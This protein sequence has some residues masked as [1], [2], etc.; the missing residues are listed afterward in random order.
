[1][2]NP[3]T[4][5]GIKIDQLLRIPDYKSKGTV[6]ESRHE[7]EIPENIKE[8][9]KV[10]HTIVAGQT[11]YGIAR[12]YG[13]KPSDIEKANPGMIR[14]SLK[15][16]QQIIIPLAQ[17]KKDSASKNFFIHKVQEKETLYSISRLYKTSVDSLK[18]I[19]GL[20][21]DSILRLGMEL[22]V[23]MV[24]G[25]VQQKDMAQTSA[26]T[27]TPVVIS[28]DCDSFLAKTEQN[29]VNLTLLLPFFASKAEGGGEDENVAEEKRHNRQK[30][31]FS[32]QSASYVEFYQGCLLALEDLKR[33]KI[34]VNLQVYD[35]E[36]DTLLLHSIM[37]KPEFQSANVVI[38]PVSLSLMN[39]ASRHMQK[40]G[41]YWVSPFADITNITKGNPFVFQV[42][43]GKENLF[44]ENIKHIPDNDTNK[45]IVVYNGSES[46]INDDFRNAA[47]K[48]KDLKVA[49]MWK[50]LN[51]YHNGFAELVSMLDSTKENIII[52]PSV[53]EIFVSNLLSIL[54]S[55]LLL[56][57]I[58][59]IG[60]TEWTLFSSI[61]MNYLFDQQL[62]YNTPFYIDYESEPVK[63]FLKKY[64]LYFGTEPGQM[65]KQGFNYA[66][67]GYDVTY[68]F[69]MG[70]AQ[71]GN[72]L[73][74]AT[75]CFNPEM[76]ITQFRFQKVSPVG[77]MINS[78]LHKVS[79][80]RDYNVLHE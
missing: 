77:G 36:N 55:K 32:P 39:Y 33:K 35:T 51:V 5:E 30:S 15:P 49:S 69:T 71:Y 23:P 50:E 29:Q 13:L 59:V 2:Y 40:N 14:D 34:D 64:R 48:S 31:M 20:S 18:I 52:S 78:T 41:T 38:G 24:V 4:T 1:A 80:T 63:R 75:L 61:D 11:L 28:M 44:L 58:K 66:M 37:K 67:L 43:A 47:A 17:L 62:S 22:K 60:R 56:Y 76:L 25:V 27:S 16:G 45:V 26:E 70:Y 10:Q 3:G 54:E 72:K 19:N 8:P 21:N 7:V 9:A 68:Y 65:S 42:N 53:D 6:Y 79:Y 12:I 57:R 73:P 46:D 74:L